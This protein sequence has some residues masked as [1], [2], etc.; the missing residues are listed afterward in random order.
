MRNIFLSCVVLLM[1]ACMVSA[2]ENA[3]VDKEY[4][5]SEDDILSINVRN[6]P[7][8]TVSQRPVRMDGRITLPMLGEMHVSGK[9]TRQLEEE[10]TKRLEYLVKEPLVQV[11]VDKVASHW[12]TL[13]G[14]V[15]RTGRYTIGSS[16]SKSPTTVLDVIST[17]GGPTIGAKITKIKIVRQVNGREVQFEFNYK[18]VLQGKNME[19]NITLENRDVI[20]V[21]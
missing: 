12:V 17:A 7:E 21:P 9:T 20:L 16:F 14:K 10:I 18:D 13:V 3:V 15:G 8:Y 19:Q 2:Q 11:F 6:E 5:I 1:F 4:V